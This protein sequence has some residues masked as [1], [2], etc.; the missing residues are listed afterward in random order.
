MLLRRL[1]E[2]LEL[3]TSSFALV[4]GDNSELLF[5]QV[6]LLLL[7]FLLF[8][9]PPSPIERRKRKENERFSIVPILAATLLQ[10]TYE[11]IGCLQVCCMCAGWQ[12]FK[13]SAQTFNGRRFL[14]VVP[15][16]QDLWL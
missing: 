9:L 13:N 2:A 15:Q 12:V 6:L 11:P 1:T 4:T 10:F 16:P 7:L 14:Y 5:V 8:V 3:G